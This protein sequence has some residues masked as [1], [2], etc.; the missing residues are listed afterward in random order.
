MALDQGLEIIV[1]VCV[2]YYQDPLPDF[3]VHYL[4]DYIVVLSLDVFNPVHSEY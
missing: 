4:I 3:T 1:L 2:E